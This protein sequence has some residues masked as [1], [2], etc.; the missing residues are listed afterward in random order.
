MIRC[1]GCGDRLNQQVVGLDNEIIFW[2]LALC[3]RPAC[4]QSPVPV[5]LRRAGEQQW[6]QQQWKLMQQVLWSGYEEPDNGTGDR[7]PG[8]E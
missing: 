4:R 7:I 3:A 6:L 5:E 8:L 1:Q 2:D